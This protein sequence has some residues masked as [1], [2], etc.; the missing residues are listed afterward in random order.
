MKFL[1]VAGLLPILTYTSQTPL[2]L[3]G[4][5]AVVFC[6]TIC[7]KT[8]EVLW[9]FHQVRNAV[10]IAAVLEVDVPKSGGVPS[11]VHT[12]RLKSSG[13]KEVDVTIHPQVSFTLSRGKSHDIS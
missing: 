13:C 11:D 12:G 10:L 1:G 5:P 2:K 7:V 9:R 4:T 6:R 3:F 8:P